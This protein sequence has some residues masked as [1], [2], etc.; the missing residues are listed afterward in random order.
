M[1]EYGHVIHV[2]RDY[3]FKNE[4]L[5]YRFLEQEKDR[6]HALNHDKWFDIVPE[7]FKGKEVDQEICAE[8]M[9]DLT[10]LFKNSQSAH[11][12]PML[13]DEASCTMYDNVRPAKWVDPK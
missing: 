11:L 8:K 1:V 13:F 2:R 6:G 12:Y 4:N 3:Q 9:K 10:D 5:F 7:E